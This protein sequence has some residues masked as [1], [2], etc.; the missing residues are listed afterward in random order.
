MPVHRLEVPAISPQ[1]DT[2]SPVEYF[3]RVYAAFGRAEAQS[4][5]AVERFFEIG[6]YVIALRFAGPALVIPIT[7]AIAHL[8]I[9][10]GPAPA[11]Q[12]RKGNF[13]L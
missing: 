9:P 1:T 8:S 3:S 2:P 11:A 10:S 5:L 7:R 4:S 6:G 12:I 13:Q